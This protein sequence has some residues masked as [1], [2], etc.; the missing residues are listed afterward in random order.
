MKTKYAVYSGEPYEESWLHFLTTDEK[1]AKWYC[2]EYNKFN[3]PSTY[4]Y[5]EH[6]VPKCV[7]PKYRLEL[8]F[9]FHKDT[10]ELYEASTAVMSVE[11][12]QK[13]NPGLFIVKVVGRS[14]EEC[15]MVA[16]SEYGLFMLNEI[17]FGLDKLP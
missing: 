1:Y 9:Y 6:L 5:V 11:E 8:V 16:N 14:Y 15:L 4:Y 10:G 3:A 7:R 13:E 17:F 12:E 2:E